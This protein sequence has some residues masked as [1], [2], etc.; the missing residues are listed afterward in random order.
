MENSLKTE[1]SNLLSQENNPPGFEQKFTIVNQ[2]AW[3]NRFLR[4]FMKSSIQ[5]NE[6]EEKQ[7]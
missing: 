7:N 6:N 4:Y 1:K 5:G 3:D 2:T